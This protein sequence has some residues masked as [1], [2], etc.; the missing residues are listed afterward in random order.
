MKT[1]NKVLLSVMTATFLVACGGSSSS[2]STN[3]E[4]T[5]SGQQSTQGQQGK[6]DLKK[7]YFLN[8]KFAFKDAKTGKP[9]L[10]DMM[11]DYFKFT[12]DGV[13]TS[14]GTMTY[15]VVSGM[16]KLYGM[17]HDLELKGIKV[18]EKEGKIFVKSTSTGKEYYFE[19]IKEKKEVTIPVKNKVEFTKE[20]LV[21]NTYALYKEDGKLFSMIGD[22]TFNEDGSVNSTTMGKLSYNIKN[23]LL[24]MTQFEKNKKLQREDSSK[25]KIWFYN[26]KYDKNYYFLKK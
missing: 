8:K 20:E 22:I 11:G 26:G 16:L 10:P 25:T 19:E 15:E 1:F 9:F 18:E 12:E 21:G 24:N 14:K 4:E 2:S 6:V 13:E 3:G 5:Q 23:G 7:T 17:P